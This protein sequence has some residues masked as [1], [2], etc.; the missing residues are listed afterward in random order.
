M[1]NKH[2]AHFAQASQSLSGI[3]TIDYY[4]AN[5]LIYAY[6]QA[7]NAVLYHAFMALSES[8][9]QGHTCLPLTV[10]A[11]QCWASAPEKGD[12]AAK[13]GFQFP[14]IS[15][16]EALFSNGEFKE[17]ANNP[18]IYWQGCLY[19]RRYF[20]FEKKLA[21]SI[22]H[23]IN[24]IDK[25]PYDL[26]ILQQCLQAVFPENDLT[27]T[28]TSAKLTISNQVDWQLISVANALN[29][30][31][32]IITGGPGTGKTYTVTKL[33]AAI[34]LRAQKMEQNV[35]V[36]AMVAPTGKAAQRLSESIA[37]TSAQFSGLICD[38]ILA[39]IP[40]QAQ[41]IHRLLGV[42][43][44]QNYFKH[45]Q[46]NPLAIEVLLIDEASMVD[47]AL[48]TRL[49]NALP[50]HCQVILLG[51]ADQLPSVQSGAVL[52]ELA[53]KPHSGYSY[54]NSHYLQTLLGQ[55]LPALPASSNEQNC[56]Y[57][58]LLTQSRRFDNQGGIG[59][60]ANAVISGEAAQ[61]WHLLKTKNSQLNLYA[62]ANLS[63]ENDYF[64]DLIKQYYF[65]LLTAKTVTEA[66]TLFNKFRVLVATRKGRNG[67]EYLNELIKEQLKLLWQKQTNQLLLIDKL[68][69]GQPIMICENNYQ[70]GL[71]NGDIGFI[72]RDQQ[73]HLMAFFEGDSKTQTTN[74][75]TDKNESKNYRTFMISQLP[76]YETVYAMTI[77]KTQ[78]SEFNHVLMILPEQSDH[79]L[80][81]RELLYTGITRAKQQ[82]TVLAKAMVWQQAVKQKVVRY[83]NLAKRLNSLAQYNH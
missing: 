44:N 82:L 66:F 76:Q 68:Y 16:L 19:L 2:Y 20:Y 28:V 5:Q 71:F 26:A 39:A 57:L 29:K 50:D 11:N 58:T 30:N 18:V 6:K 60:L 54:K 25:Q 21:S 23:K 70:V 51:D 31:F 63:I 1:K 55:K 9:R 36:I 22:Y 45:H 67:V 74:I 37:K 40:S 4:L 80:L 52:N 65:P 77:H 33:L 64:H 24:P 42:V 46:E 3:E 69:H 34:V 14:T 48:M 75:T 43:P 61:S 78:G 81:S 35:P 56:D 15:L 7:D 17:E 38:S 8:L 27:P 10:L 73:G 41:T 59:L 53:P 79:Q 13:T 12:V 32:S 49:F 72:W 83:S 47:L 62:S